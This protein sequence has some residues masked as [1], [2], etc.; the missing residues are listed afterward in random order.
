MIDL[1]YTLQSY[2]FYPS[3]QI[4]THLLNIQQHKSNNDIVARYAY[5]KLHK[6]KKTT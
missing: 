2:K 5:C 3:M 1:G 6:T 4:P